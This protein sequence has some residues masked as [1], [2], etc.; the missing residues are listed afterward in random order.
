METES[1]KTGRAMRD[2]LGS[3][4]LAALIVDALLRANIIKEVDIE[5]VLG[6]VAEEIEVRM[7]LG[8]YEASKPPPEGDPAAAVK[9]ATD[10]KDGDAERTRRGSSAD[11]RTCV[12]AR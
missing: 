10:R 6:I 3:K 7:S 11:L 12:V 1:V 9:E 5:R 4:E 2:A 8:D